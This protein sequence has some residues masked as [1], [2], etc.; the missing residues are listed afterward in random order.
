MPSS[1]PL[2]LPAVTSEDDAIDTLFKS[3]ARSGQSDSSS[4]S[5]SAMRAAAALCFLDDFYGCSPTTQLP[6]SPS[7]RTRGREQGWGE[8]QTPVQTGVSGDR[9]IT[10]NATCFLSRPHSTIS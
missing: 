6:P 2:A 1:L 8:I 10:S 9:S 4:E 3:V 5:E 7:S